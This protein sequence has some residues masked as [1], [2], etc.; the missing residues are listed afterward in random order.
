[1]EVIRRFIDAKKIMSIMPLP[2]T[3][4]NRRLEIIVMPA[5]DNVETIKKDAKIENIVDLLTGSIPDNEMSLADYRD[6]RLGKYETI[7]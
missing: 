5:E 2:E 3:L 7:D 4:R 1:M 6:E